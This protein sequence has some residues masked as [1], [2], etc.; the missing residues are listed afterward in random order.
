MLVN[1]GRSLNLHFLMLNEAWM[2]ELYLESEGP[3]ISFLDLFPRQ[4][5]P[6]PAFL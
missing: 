4:C 5:G 6:K 2:G 1:L 3:A